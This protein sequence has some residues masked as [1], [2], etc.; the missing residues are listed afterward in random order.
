M[1]EGTAQGGACWSTQAEAA[2]MFC[3][4]VGGT[5]SSGTRSCVGVSEGPSATAGGPLTFSYTLRVDGA[6]ASDAAVAGYLPGCETYGVDY[7]APVLSLFAL[8]L[9]ALACAKF[10]ARPFLNDRYGV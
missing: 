1:A 5:A 8:A 3:S 9:I 6:A 10:V 2:A 7:W 4:A